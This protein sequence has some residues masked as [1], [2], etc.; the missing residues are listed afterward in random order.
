MT[1]IFNAKV[2]HDTEE[3]INPKKRS[4]KDVRGGKVVKEA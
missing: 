2:R 4:Q 1:C 3:N